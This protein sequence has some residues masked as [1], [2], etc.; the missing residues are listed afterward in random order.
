MDADALGRVGR[1]L[2][3]LD[4]MRFARPDED[5]V[6]CD[7]TY[8]AAV[9]KA[10]E[11][12]PALRVLKGMKCEYIPEFHAF[13]EDELFGKSNVSLVTFLGAGHRVRWRGHR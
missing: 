1:S 7:F 13:Y 5:V 9:D 6:H 11:D 4:K 8:V 12:Y 3:W 2:Q 10:K